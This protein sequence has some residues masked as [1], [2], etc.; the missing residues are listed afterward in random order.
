MMPSLSS[1]LPLVLI[2]ILIL[3]VMFLLRRKL[4]TS[5]R[6]ITMLS[7][8]VVIWIAAFL[9]HTFDERCL[10]IIVLKSINYLCLTTAASAQLLFAFSYTN[11]TRWLTTIP[12]VLLLIVPTLTQILFWAEPSRK[13]LFNP[14]HRIW[15]QANL[16]YNSHLLAAS[17]ILLIDTFL[18]KPRQHFLRAWTIP[19]GSIFPMLGNILIFISHGNLETNIYIAVFS[20]SLA[21]AG[22]AYGKFNGRLIETTPLQGIWLLKAWTTVG[23][24]LTTMIK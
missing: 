19:A 3:G 12:Y 7:T 5:A 1:S 20:Y 14:E 13:I 2:F 21:I 11:R 23:W 10:P 17:I 22:F 8:I 24:L 6:A 18:G 9:L 15:E 16:I 4:P